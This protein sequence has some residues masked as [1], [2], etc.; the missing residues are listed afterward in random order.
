MSSQG[1][2]SAPCVEWGEGL[3]PPVFNFDPFEVLTALVVLDDWFGFAQFLSEDL[4]EKHHREARFAA[5]VL[6]SMGLAPEGKFMEMP[7]D[8]RQ[9]ISAM[10]WADYE[11]WL[12]EHELGMWG[13]GRDDERDAEKTL[14]A[15]VR[16]FASVPQVMEEV[17][18]RHASSKQPR[19]SAKFIK[20]CERKLRDL[21]STQAF[22]PSGL[23]NA[24]E[25]PR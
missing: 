20:A 12:Q 9:R 5:N 25:V 22:G 13:W 1:R 7:S 18:K 10:P 23:A 3:N 6:R 15:W 14:L 4:R 21:F 24:E 2:K 17:R 16:A 8:M 19:D 11:A